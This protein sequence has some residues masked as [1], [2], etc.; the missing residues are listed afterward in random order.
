MFTYIAGDKKFVFQLALSD[1][2]A[3]NEKYDGDISQ[4]IKQA[5][6]ANNIVKIVKIFEDIVAVSS[7]ILD[8]KHF[9]PDVFNYL[10]YALSVD[11]KLCDK[12]INAILPGSTYR[13]TYIDYRYDKKGDKNMNSFKNNY[14]CCESPNAPRSSG[15]YPWGEK[16]DNN[17][18]D[19]PV[20][21]K[22]PYPAIDR[23]ITHNERVVIVKFVDGTF[24]KAVCSPNDKFDIDMGI[25]VCLMKKVLGGSTQ[26]NNLIRRIHKRMDKL[27][28]DKKAENA[29]RK[30]RRDK[31][32][33]IKAKRDKGREEASRSFR[34]DISKAVVSALEAHD[35]KIAKEDSK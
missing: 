18:N 2:A 19:M 7:K 23:V 25:T 13:I 20:K 24:T 21:V 9:Y 1:I 10:T 22:V 3:L 32:A 26:Y 12:F 27:E 4:T 14:C 31:Q 5:I 35:K 8:L 33:A 34:E 15:R 29:A 17:T 28:S 16:R 11:S 30:A 6:D